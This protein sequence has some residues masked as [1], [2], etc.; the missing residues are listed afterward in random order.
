MTPDR[1]TTG[2]TGPRRKR[3]F[4]QPSM[5]GNVAAA[6]SEGK[7]RRRGAGSPRPR[8]CSR[9][10]GRCSVSGGASRR[11]GRSARRARTRTRAAGGRRFTVTSPQ[12][13]RP[14]WP[15]ISSSRSLRWM[16]SRVPAGFAA[17]RRHGQPARQVGAGFDGRQR[18]GRIGRG[19][20][21]RG[22]EIGRVGHDMVEAAEIGRQR[23]GEVVNDRSHPVGHAVE[24][25]ISFGQLGQRRLQLDADDAAACQRA[26][27]GKGR[28]RRRRRRDRG[29]AAPGAASTAAAS[30]TASM[31]TR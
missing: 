15:T 14:R 23:P 31:A 19:I 25:G 26:R 9:P 11:V 3:S 1:R 28:R 20:G 17:R 12:P 16:M 4:N 5:A 22:G 24:V 8:R 30:S 21:D 2:T 6:T 10:S 18:L 13:R 7:R 29:C 27:P